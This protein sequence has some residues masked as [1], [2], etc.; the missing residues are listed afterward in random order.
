MRILKWTAGTIAVLVIAIVVFI[1]AFDWNLLRGYIGDKVT[2]QT[3]REFS[4]GGD[5]DVRLGWPPRIHAEQVRLQNAPWGVEPYML[6]LPVVEFTIRLLPLLRGQVVFPEVA[7]SRPVIVLEKNASGE[8]N[9]ELTKEEEDKE[10]DFPHIG[11]LVVDEGDITY[12]DPA[13]ATEIK[14]QVASDTARTEAVTRFSAKGKYKAKSASASGTAGSVFSLFDQTQPFPLAGDVQVGDTKAKLDGTITGLATFD[15]ANLNLDLS[16]K[17]LADLL[18]I[19]GITLP[20]TPPYQVRG[21]LVRESNL[22]RFNDFAGKVGDSDL[23]G[24]LSVATNEERPRLV[25]NLSS[26]TLDFDDLSGF[27]GKTAETGAGETSSA[28]QRQKKAQEKSEAGVF[29]EKEFS[30]DRLTAI[31]ADVK[32]RANTI[33]AREELP[34]DHLDTHLVLENGA[35]TLKPLNFGVAEGNVVSD[36]VMKAA[37][38][39]MTIAANVRFQRLKLNQ[40]LPDLGAAKASAGVI[41]G[42]S[43]FSASGSSVSQW[44]ESVDGDFALMMSGGHVSNLLLEFIGLDGGEVMKFLFGGDKQVGLRCAVADFGVKDGVMNAQTFVVDT[45]DTKVLGE[46]RVLLGAEKLELKLKPLPKD[47]SIL[48]FR[49]PIHIQGTFEDPA[50]RPDKKLFLRA[51]AAVALGF[52]TP[53]AALIPLI[54]TGPGEDSNCA[55]LIAEAK[56]AGAAGRSGVSQRDKRGAKKTVVKPAQ[57]Q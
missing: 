55:Q 40:L 46:G 28:E 13:I 49:S 39:P 19:L 5:L 26:K 11:R 18:P 20:Q 44:A 17:T 24:T 27:I 56:S 32:Y 50:V 48:S 30:V 31:N 3:G 52:V 47:A 23:A 29:P 57:P 36:F 41:G 33:R 16:G 10:T 6:D 54:E 51:G 21:Q 37:A 1:F 7:F 53:L 9:W 43:N 42:Q 38:K 2:A 22:W 45:T 4:I 12:R 34:L 15:A 35:L 25:A 8:G 14:A